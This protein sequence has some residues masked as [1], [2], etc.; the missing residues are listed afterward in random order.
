MIYLDWNA[1]APLCDAAAATIRA[2]DTGMQGN[3]S[4]IHGMGR[5]ARARIEAARQ[6]IQQAIPLAG[7]ATRPDGRAMVFTSGGTEANATVGQLIDPA[8]ILL[9]DP[10]GHPSLCALA[11]RLPPGQAYPV[12][13]HP[14]NHAAAGRIDVESLGSRLQQL[15][16]RG[17]VMVSAA[18][19]ETGI[20]QPLAAIRRVAHAHGFLVIA[21][22]AQ[23]V[24]RV[25][26]RDPQGIWH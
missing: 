9:Y 24:G 13:I 5:Q 26:A 14:K 1:G 12:D 16:G 7:E 25:D 8:S 21:D 18:N 15:G 17:F 22:I 23:L 19:S 10:T 2:G 3:P 4:S 11:E 6:Q 20:L